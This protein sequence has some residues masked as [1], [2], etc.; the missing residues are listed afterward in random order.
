MPARTDNK[1][2]IANVGDATIV[3]SEHSLNIRIR[4]RMDKRMKRVC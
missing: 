3:E 1:P 2:S 4:K